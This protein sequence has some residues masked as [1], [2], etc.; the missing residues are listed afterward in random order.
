M[1]PAASGRKP[2]QAQVRDRRAKMAA[3]ILGVALLAVG[4]LQGPKLLKAIDGGSAKLT[5]TDANV[6]TS[7]AVVA[8][9]GPSLGSG[10]V[11]GLTLL[12]QHPAPFHSQMP[13]VAAVN[14]GSG[15]PA[16]GTTTNA[17][18]GSAGKATATGTT[19]TATTTTSKTTTPAV[20]TPTVT[21]NP[22]ALTLPVTPAPTGP[23]AAV[24]KVDGKT[25]YIGVKGTFPAKSPLFELVSFKGKK[26]RIKV[27]GGS[28]SGGE[29]YLLLEPKQQVTFVNQ[30]DGSKMVVKFVKTTH[31]DSPEQLTSPTTGSATAAPTSSP[32]AGT[33]TSATG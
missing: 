8:S 11:A 10:Q 16:A 22:A 20:T 7:A 1:M 6:T 25:E 5:V 27:V 30:V 29:P 19:T 24:L 28:F 18:K 26:A 3:I 33:T 4:F 12:K 2:T 13:V 21:T 31:V 23:I 15:Q 14:S 17:S 9:I 32:S